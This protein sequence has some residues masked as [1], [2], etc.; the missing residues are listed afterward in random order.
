VRSVDGGRDPGA[1]EGPTCDGDRRREDGRPVRADHGCF[2]CC[3]VCD[4]DGHRCPG[5]GAGTTH[6]V[7]VCLR[8]CHSVKTTGHA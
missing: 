3:V 8:C 5:C 2:R 7:Q 1:P 4:Q 6:A